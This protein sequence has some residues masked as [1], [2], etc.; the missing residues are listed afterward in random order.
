MFLKSRKLGILGVGNMGQAIIKALIDSGTFA[1]SRIHFSNRSSG[2]IE[3]VKRLYDINAHTTN[4]E[5]VDNSDILIIAVKPQDLEE[6]VEPCRSSFRKDQIIISL[7][8]GVEFKLLRR[9]IPEGH[10]TRVML[11]TPVFVRKGVVGFLSE[12]DLY[13]EPLRELLS[14]LG[15]VI[16]L[17]DGDPFEAFTVASS[18]GTGFIFELMSY[19]QDW[20]EE[21]GISTEEAR[22][23][24][25][26]T[27]L[28]TAAMAEASQ[29]TFEELQNK[30]TSKKGMTA[31][32]LE[33]MRSLEIEGLMRMSFSK[34]AQRYR[35]L[36]RS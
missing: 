20:I 29:E 33:S 25:V 5:L 12:N 34:A 23:I 2:K 3:K 15:A 16:K 30:V 22:Q 6:A 26:Q 1:A 14:P 11:N 27:F 4:E 9:L 24:V 28:G 36:G 31:A 35:E 7:A 10:L 18:S 17:E 32:G 21:H 13:E 19:W 8:A